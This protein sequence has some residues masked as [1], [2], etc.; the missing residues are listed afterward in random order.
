MKIAIFENEFDTLEMAFKYLNKKYFNNTLI[1]EN[2]PRSQSFTNLN[3]LSEYILVIIDIDLSSQ[4]N[5]DGFG[6]IRKIEST[7][8]KV[9]KI[10]ILTGQELSENYNIE[11]GLTQKYPVLEKPV[12]YQKI[13]KEFDKLNITLK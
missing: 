1:F 6:L 7:L 13:K 9:P 8:S 5:E 12:N 4:S 10:L 11:N 2:Y 3:E